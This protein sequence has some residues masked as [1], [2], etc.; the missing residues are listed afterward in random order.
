[1]YKLHGKQNFVLPKVL[2]FSSVL[3]NSVSVVSYVFNNIL[4]GRSKFKWTLNNIR[5]EKVISVP[6]SVTKAFFEVSA[7]LDVRHCPKLQSFVTSRK[8]N[9]QPWQNGK[10]PNFGPSLDPRKIFSW[11]LLLLIVRQ[12]SKPK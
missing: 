8:H 6:I 11:L 2:V 1:M 5:I 9:M 12:C 3:T 4:K 10:S 7:L